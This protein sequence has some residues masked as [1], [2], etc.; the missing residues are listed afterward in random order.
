MSEHSSIRMYTLS[1]SSKHLLNLTTCALSTLR[2]MRISVRIFWRARSFSKVL[3]AT[4]FAAKDS[5]VLGSCIEYTTANPPLPSGRP[6]TYERVRVSPE[7]ASLYVSVTT[8]GHF[9][10]LGRSLAWPP[11][12]AVGKAVVAVSGAAR[13]GRGGR[14]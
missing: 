1:L 8:R 11:R 5:P 4:T 14:R 3:F 2:W 10:S 13:R 12:V 7:R 9:T 6:R